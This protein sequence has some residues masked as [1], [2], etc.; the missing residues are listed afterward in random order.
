VT[1]TIAGVL[2]ATGSSNGFAYD[3]KSNHSELLPIPE[4][5]IEADYN[6]TQ[7]YGY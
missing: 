2:N 7:D 5:A 1:S 3:F 4:A 6:L